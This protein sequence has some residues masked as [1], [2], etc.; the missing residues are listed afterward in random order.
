MPPELASVEVHLLPELTNP[1]DL[2]GDV[3]VVIDV[4]RAST[5]LAAAFQSGNP[6]IIPC[7]EVAE[8]RQLAEQHR[9]A[10]SK[11][12][13][14]GGERGGERI[15]GFD[16][17][18]SP[19]EFADSEMD[20]VTVIFT[21]TNGTRAMMRCM[22]AARVL[23]GSFVNLRRIVDAVAGY[24]RIHLIC[25][26][27]A[28]QISWEDSLCAGAIVENLRQRRGLTVND[29]GLL[30]EM[31]WLQIGADGLPKPV[32]A[33]ALRHGQGGRN[34]IAIDRQDDIHWAAQ[35]DSVEV[36]PELFLSNWTISRQQQNGE[37]VQ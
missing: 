33:E 8:A 16:L 20:D 2:A 27:T 36:V 24:D 13:L 25:A 30:A 35:V 17:G 4:L 34:L 28:G 10:G 12:V 22:G 15:R 23:V 1:H 3:V 18:N 6:T 11:R 5:T 26:G 19:A 9:A 37:A 21:T 7:L 31:K 14:L 32:L 29:A